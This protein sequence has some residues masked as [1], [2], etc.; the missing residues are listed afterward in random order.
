MVK[1][2]G[3]ADAM[4]LSMNALEKSSGLKHANARDLLGMKQDHDYAIHRDNYGVARDRLDH[5]M[6]QDQF[7]NRFDVS[8]FNVGTDEE[9]TD[10]WDESKTKQIRKRPGTQIDSLTGNPIVDEYIRRE[11]GM[12]THRGPVVGRLQ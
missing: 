10:P 4:N 8:K 5:D 1:P 9:H 11:A 3:F 7:Q 12:N 2:I 6:G